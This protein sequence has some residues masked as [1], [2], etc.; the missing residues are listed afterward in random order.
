[1]DDVVP[2]MS[3]QRC[4]WQHPITQRRSTEAPHDVVRVARSL[5]NHSSGGRRSNVSRKRLCSLGKGWPTAFMFYEGGA[6]GASSR[7]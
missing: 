3:R 7:H 5:N 6:D 4:G 1:M 2:K